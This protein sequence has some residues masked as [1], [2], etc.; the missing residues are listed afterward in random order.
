MNRKLAN[1]LSAL[2][3]VTAVSGL[4]YLTLGRFGAPPA[5]PGSAAPAEQGYPP[6]ATE[7][8]TPRPPTATPDAEGYL[9]PPAGLPW[10]QVGLSDGPHAD[11]L[12]Q[13]QTALDAGDADTP[14]SWVADDRA[15]L[16]LTPLNTMETEGGLG[17]YSDGVR[18]L[19]AAYYTAGASP[20]VQGYF[21]RGPCLDVLLHRLPAPMPH[22]ATPPASG[23]P[24]GAPA[25]DVIEAEAAALHIC[26]LPG[27]ALFWDRW[28]YGDYEALLDRFNGYEP[29]PGLTYF[30]IRP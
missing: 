24:H 15:G 29:D 2:A 7:T 30:M 11:L 16:G 27:A 23:D 3:L 25:P 20:R 19:L 9:P 14:S 10:Q 28:V 4:V 18:D 17:L 22:P 21:E 12:M 1:L 13:V 6:P 5:A 26:E 8:P